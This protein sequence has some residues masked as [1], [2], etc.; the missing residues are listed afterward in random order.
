M[1][2][3]WWQAAAAAGLVVLA[4][5]GITAA[6]T[7]ALPRTLSY[8]LIRQACEWHAGWQTRSW[9]E[10]KS[11]HFRLRYRPEDAEVAPLVLQTAETAYEP[12]AAMLQ[13]Q[14]AG[15]TLVVLY[16]D[17]ESL[18]RQFG[19]AAS[20]SAMGVYWGGVVRV[21]SPY[22]WVNSRDLQQIAAIFNSSGPVAHEFAHLLVDEK[23]R[24]NYP[25][26]L[27]EGIAQYVEK[28]LT[29]F[30]MPGSPEAAGWYALQEMDYEFDNLADQTLAYRQSALM[31]D[32]LVERYGLESLNL[33]LDRLGRGATLDQAFREIIDTS[34]ANL[35]VA[36]AREV[37]LSRARV[38]FA[39]NL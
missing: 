10:I 25:R 36:F 5:V 34:S 6:H 17:R 28:Q 14:P 38:E 20:E 30:V 13:Y 15:K 24:G 7:S 19:W 21:L 39:S 9:P 4:A 33:V 32:Y 1:F 12:A 23:A 11:D 29:G 2:H 26:W 37:P 3:N 31:V 8:S 35:A 18:A 27:T 22:D 16:P